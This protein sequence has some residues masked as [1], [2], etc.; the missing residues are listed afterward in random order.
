[1]QYGFDL[2]IPK[3]QGE[4]YEGKDYSYYGKKHNKY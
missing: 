1:L 3:A 4:E 2:W